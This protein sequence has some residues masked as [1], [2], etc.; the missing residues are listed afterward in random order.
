MKAKSWRH[1][2]KKILSSQI[3][4]MIVLTGESLNECHKK[5]KIKLHLKTNSLIL[6]V[7]QEPISLNT[8]CTL[9]SKEIKIKSRITVVKFDKPVYKR[10]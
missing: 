9:N 10:T 7:Y 4:T 1:G 6:R 5:Q 3:C 8:K 2:R